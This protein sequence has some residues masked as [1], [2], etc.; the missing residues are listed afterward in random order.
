MRSTTNS[1]ENS[2]VS[3]IDKFSMVIK[4]KAALNAS[5]YPIGSAVPEAVRS[6][7]KLSPIRSAVGSSK[8]VGV[9]P[10]ETA[11]VVEPL[12]APTVKTSASGALPNGSVSNTPPSISMS[13]GSPEVKLV[14]PVTVSE[15]EAD[16]DA[17]NRVV[18]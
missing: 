9:S 15:T 14:I 6:I 16:A 3:L 13:S 17:E 2:T 11:E 5:A 7:V 4:P 18:A 8:S 12:A 1:N 10:G